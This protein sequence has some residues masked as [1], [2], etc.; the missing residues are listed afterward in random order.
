MK[1]FILLF[2]ASLLWFS[3]KGYTSIHPFIGFEVG[4]QNGDGA[5]FPGFLGGASVGLESKHIGMEFNVTHFQEATKD[6]EGYREGNLTL[7]PLG[8]NIFVSPS[9]GGNWHLLAKGGVSYVM[10][11]RELSPQDVKMEGYPNYK[12]SEEIKSGVG[13]QFG[14]GLE[15]RATEHL[16]INFEVMQFFFNSTIKHTRKDMNVLYGGEYADEGQIELDTILGLIGI[17][18][19]W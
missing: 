8:L 11:D 7:M 13:Y 19:L 4:R 15:Y 5:I 9:I 12:V 10:T 17:K 2:I 1:R 14:G 6:M 16:A 18:Y 3:E